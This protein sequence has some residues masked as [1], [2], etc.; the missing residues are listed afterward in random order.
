MICPNCGSENTNEAT[1]CK[2]CGQRFGPSKTAVQTPKIQKT[3]PMTAGI[4]S[5][6]IPTAEY[7]AKLGQPA[8][9]E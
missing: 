7:S 6:T 8:K 2:F 5:R 4:I 3:T 1:F 9:L